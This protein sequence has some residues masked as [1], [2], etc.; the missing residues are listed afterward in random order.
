MGDERDQEA[1]K[2]IEVAKRALSDGDLQKSVK[3]LKKSLNFRHSTTAESLL[4]RVEE[5]LASSTHPHRAAS[6]PSTPASPP[7]AESKSDASHAGPT[8]RPAAAAAAASTPK[9]KPAAADTTEDHAPKK[10]FTPEQQAAARKIN[11]TTDYYEIL[12]IERSAD[13]VVIKAAY[14]KM[15][16]KFHPDKNHAPEAEEAFKKVS[17]AYTTLS[18]ANEREYYNQN[19]H[20]GNAQRAARQA[21]AQGGYHQQQPMTPEELFN[22]FF[23]SQGMRRQ[24]HHRQQRHHNGGEQQQQ[25]G[26]IGQFLHFLP[27]ILLFVFSFLSGPSSEP[28]LFNLDKTDLH[29]VRRTTPL[30]TPYFVTP[31]FSRNYA[32]DYRALAQVEAQVDAAYWKKLEDGCKVEMKE[33]KSKIAEAKKAKGDHQADLL[34][35]AHSM[36]LPNCARLT[37]LG[38]R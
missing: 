9:P 3:F 37:E 20:R 27:L 12:G 2:C 4:K 28:T 8:R 6:P 26:G 31:Q 34:L 29:S 38:R 36:N 11:K 1:E 24:F 15:A 25:R 18:D 23:E 14:R 19:G 13:E 5:E 7:S 16:L 21:Y 33:Q 10:N 22:M 35:K 32:R 17:E 30:H